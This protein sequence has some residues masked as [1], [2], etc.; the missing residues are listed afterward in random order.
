MGS[1]SRAI[2]VGLV[3]LLA[4]CSSSRDYREYGGDYEED[5]PTTIDFEKEREEK[6]RIQS[7]VYKDLVERG[8]V[9]KLY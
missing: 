7:R 3:G 5:R 8:S 4:S 6:L 1:L 9:L 2:G